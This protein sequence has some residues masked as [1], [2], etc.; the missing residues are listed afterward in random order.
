MRNT[1]ALALVLL[2]AC[3][4]D[5]LPPPS[6][7]RDPAN[8][9][10]PEPRFTPGPNPL[11]RPIAPAPGAGAPEAAGH[12]GHGGASTAPA[13]ANPHAGHA[14]GAAASGSAMPMPSTSGAA[15]PMP[16]PSS[17]GSAMP[18][19]MPKAP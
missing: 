11:E 5:D 2:V 17:S 15:M 7:P 10:A 8:A 4:S 9:R 18:M 13:M 19:P 3:A 14:M 1:S 12:A 6:S 16:M